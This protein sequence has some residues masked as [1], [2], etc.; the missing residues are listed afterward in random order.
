MSQKTTDPMGRPVEFPDGV[1]VDALR[2]ATT[3][4]TKAKQP[5]DHK[6]KKNTQRAEVENHAITFPW[7]GEDWTVKASD[8]TSL[9]FLAALEDA[10]ADDD[11]GAVIRAMRA[12]LGREQAARLFKG[13]QVEHIAEFFTAAGEAAGTGNR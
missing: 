10:E 6:K 9:E 11:P 4:P 3:L 12:L 13:R 1:D 5:Q 2:A 8:M 7:D